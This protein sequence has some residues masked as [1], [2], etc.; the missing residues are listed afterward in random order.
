M[1]PTR[2][3]ISARSLKPLVKKI[4]TLPSSIQQEPKEKPEKKEVIPQFVLTEDGTP[5]I[6][7]TELPNFHK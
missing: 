7:Y 6:L 4:K 3:W 1:L 2:Y 5:I